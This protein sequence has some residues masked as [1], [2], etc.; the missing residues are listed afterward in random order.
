MKSD[1]TTSAIPLP[2]SGALLFLGDY[3]GTLAA[4]RCL[5]AHGIDTQL[6]EDSGQTRTSVS[7]FLSGTVT[8]P[9]LQDATNFVEWLIEQGPN[10]RGRVLFPASDELVFLFAKESDRLREFYRMYLPSFATIYRIL[11]KQRLYEACA[12]AGVDYP[13]TWFPK[14][15]DELR[16]L[17]DEVNVPVILKPKTQVQMRTGAKAAEVADGVSIAVAFEQFVRDNPYGPELKAHDPDVVW[18]MV[19]HFL[20]KGAHHIYSLAGFA[21]GSERPP[22]VRAS[23][24]ILQRPRKLGI[25]LCFES[26][27]ARPELRAAVGRL[28]LELG[29]E[30]M[31][32]IEFIEHEGKELLIDFNPRG[33]SQMAFEV[34]RKMPLPLMNYLRAIGDEVRY[35][36]V[37]AEA[38]EWHG[39]EKEHVYAHGTLLG[40]VEVGQALASLTGKPSEKWGAWRNGHASGYTDA[41]R[42]HGDLKPA[43]VDAKKHLI[44]AIKHPRSFLRSFTR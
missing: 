26:A 37:R 10:M 39:R 6:V 34:A 12:K 5:G 11:N 28:C 8:S 15:T 43:L 1:A 14:G 44:Q 3:Y 27:E 17:V 42:M 25:G 7:A 16:S 35:E 4:A 29:Y 18:P 13:Q 41:V 36:R 22:I 24:K 40:I 21:D 33:Y 20:P 38:E 9:S 23:R 19:Q 30:G 2:L 32:E 31:F